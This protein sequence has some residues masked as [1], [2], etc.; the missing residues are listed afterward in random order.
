MKQIDKFILE[1]KILPSRCVRLDPFGSDQKWR[2]G[3]EASVLFIDSGY[4]LPLP[5]VK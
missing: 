2:Y 4:V 1:T 5:G 3:R